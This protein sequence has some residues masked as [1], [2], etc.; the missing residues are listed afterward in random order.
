MQRLRVEKVRGAGCRGGAQGVKKMEGLVGSG[1][2]LPWREP[3]PWRRWGRLAWSFICSL[4]GE[5]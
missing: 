2:S 4:E 5:A 1:A 3:S